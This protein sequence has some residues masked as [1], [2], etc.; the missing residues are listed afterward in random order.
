LALTLAGAALCASVASD[1]HAG[2][3]VNILVLKEHAIGSTAQAQPYIDK[4]VE[5]ARQK[6]G[7]SSAAGRFVTSRS[8]AKS[9]IR[10]KK[11][12]FGIMSLPAYLAWRSKGLTVIGTVDAA[13]GG[14]VYHL[15]SKNESGLSG[16]KGKKLASNHADDERFIN[17][18][19]SGG[20]FS[21]SDFDL[22]KTRR[23]VQTLKKVIKDKAACAL[24]DDAQYAE[25]KHVDG[26][27]SLKS[28]WK[29]STLPA[30]P[31]VALSS[32]SESQRAKF[33]ASLSAL[34]SGAGSTHCTKVGIKSLQ[35]ASESAYSSVINKY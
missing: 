18:I 33:K 10:K 24:V 14:R 17:K 12:Q 13:T 21:L 16:C 5:V 15:V 9:Y 30:M 26:G 6:N 23:P 7:W 3:D 34:C 35:P 8:R 2:S 22:M 27:S 25:L 28:V 1:S 4:L 19:V 29:S 20:A 31:V 32:A 11:P